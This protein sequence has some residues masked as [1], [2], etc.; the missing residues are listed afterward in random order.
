MIARALY[1]S[2]IGLALGAVMLGGCSSGSDWVACYCPSYVDCFYRTDGGTLGSLDNKFG[3][4]GSCFTTT[5]SYNSCCQFCNT[6]I[7]KFQNDPAARA[8][9]CTFDRPWQ[10]Q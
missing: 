2:T 8:A 3:A 10:C 5:A 1:R 4:N 6:E 7:A 9:G